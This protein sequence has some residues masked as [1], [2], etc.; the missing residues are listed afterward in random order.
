M[1]FDENA[2]A[3]FIHETL[4]RLA[5]WYTENIDMVDFS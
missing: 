4:T 3:Q 1:P 5:L 2:R